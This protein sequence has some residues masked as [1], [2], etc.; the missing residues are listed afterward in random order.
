M[1]ILDMNDYMANKPRALGMDN[2]HRINPGDSLKALEDV[3]DDKA[4]QYIS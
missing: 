4:W 3:E 1:T 2:K